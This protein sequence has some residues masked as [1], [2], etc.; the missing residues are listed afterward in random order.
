VHEL[1]ERFLG[2]LINEPG[3]YGLTEAKFIHTPQIIA[4][5]SVRLRCQYT[6]SQSHQC[7]TTPPLTP[8][9]PEVREL[10]DEYKFG[11]MLRREEPFGQRDHRE[12][13]AEFAA[14]VDR[15]EADTLSRGYP[16]AFAVGVGNCLYL[17]TGDHLRPC[18]YPAKHRPT[19]E[20]IGIELKETFEF[21]HWQPHLTRAESDPFQLFALLLVE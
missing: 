7:S 13:W 2:R 12:V 3:L 14:E 10:L 1:R 20:A 16:R 18:D 6:C 19:L 8:T 21:L 17:H 4:L 11:M 5:R 9:A 15:L